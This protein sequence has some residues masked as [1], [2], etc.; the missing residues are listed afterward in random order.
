VGSKVDPN[1][2]YW[3]SARQKKEWVHTTLKFGSVEI[4]MQAGMDNSACDKIDIVKALFGH[5]ISETPN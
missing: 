4:V 5:I 3:A 1:N 2:R